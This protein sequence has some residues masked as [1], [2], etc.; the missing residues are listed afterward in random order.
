MI[1]FDVCRKC[2]VLFQSSNGQAK[3]TTSLHYLGAPSVSNMS[4]IPS[5]CGCFWNFTIKA[6]PFYLKGAEWNRLHNVMVGGSK[7]I[8]NIG[9]MGVNCKKYKLIT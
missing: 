4:I 7:Q 8:L 6:L 9:S 1:W 5:F 3:D 2:C